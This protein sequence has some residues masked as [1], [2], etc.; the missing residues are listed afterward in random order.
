[1]CVVKILFNGFWCRKLRA[2]SDDEC[3]RKMHYL[4]NDESRCCGIIHKSENAKL[5]IMMGSA[6]WAITLKINL[7]RWP[8]VFSGVDDD[9]CW[10]YFYHSR[11]EGWLVFKDLLINMR[12]EFQTRENIAYINMKCHIESTKECCTTFRRLK[13]WLSAFPE[14]SEVTSINYSN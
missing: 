6:E 12:R 3:G 5:A 4:R 10:F 7:S 1:M 11:F 14:L 2:R 8:E 9:F 13:R